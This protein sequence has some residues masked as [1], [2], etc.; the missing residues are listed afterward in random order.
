MS[1][2]WSEAFED[3]ALTL[4]RLLDEEVMSTALIPRVGGCRQ[5]PDISSRCL[6]FPMKQPPNII[7]WDEMGVDSEV[8]GNFASPD[9]G[10]VIAGRGVDLQLCIVFQQQL[11]LR[12]TINYLTSSYRNC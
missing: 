10:V 6:K 4:H 9:T 5:L 7:Q 1:H 8:V 12:D 2:S 3:F 11:A